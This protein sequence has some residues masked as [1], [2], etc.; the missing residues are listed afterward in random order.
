MPIFEVPVTALVEAATS[1]DAMSV[2]LGDEPG[3]PGRLILR[4]ADE[5]RELSAEEAAAKLEFANELSTALSTPQTRYETDPDRPGVK[6]S[7]AAA[8]TLRR[9]RGER[10]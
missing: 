9:L 4:N 10:P 1:Q 7:P 5:P 6:F 2:A 8:A 3:R